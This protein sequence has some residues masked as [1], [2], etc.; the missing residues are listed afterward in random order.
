MQPYVVA[1]LVAL[2][3]LGYDPP[4]TTFFEKNVAPHTEIENNMANEF[5]VI[6]KMMSRLSNELTRVKL[7][8][9]KNQNY[10]HPA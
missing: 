2:T 9:G 1:P 8:Q 4:K 7:S 6:K 5:E 10:Q 3:Y